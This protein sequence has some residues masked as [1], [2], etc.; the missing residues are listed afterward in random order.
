MN[1]RVAG[2]I[3]FYQSTGRKQFTIWLARSER[4]IPMMRKVLKSHGLPTDL[5]YLAMIESGFNPRAYS[6]SRASGPW[7]FISGTGR[8]YGLKMN[9]W[10]DER[11][12]PEKSTVAAARYLKDLYDQFDSWH[13]AT[14]AYNCGEG[15]MA[16]AI[17]R[18]KT[19]D[20]WK[21]SR[22]RYLKKETRLYVPQ[23]I[24]AAII[25]KEPEKYGFNN[26]QYQDPL[27]YEGQA[28]PGGVTLKNI[29]KASGCSEQILRELNPELRQKMKKTLKKQI[30]K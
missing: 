16:R 7:Q 23:I 11:R 19:E 14:A 20:F 2:F 8:K 22:H 10:V 21:L 3:K 26:I 28:V 30:M 12:D 24:A 1:P 5:V 6:R 18:Y 15:K 13:L 25:A 4:Y 9:Y 17:K 27:D 29:A